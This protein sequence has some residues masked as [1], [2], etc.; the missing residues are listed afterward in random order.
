MPLT[1]KQLAKFVEYGYMKAEKQFGAIL[2]VMLA[3]LEEDRIKAILKA[4]LKET[5]IVAEQLIV[6]GLEYGNLTPAQLKQRTEEKHKGK[7]VLILQEEEDGE[8]AV[9]D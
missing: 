2:R 6:L 5:E 3:D 8:E 9:A 4:L 7:R 1:A